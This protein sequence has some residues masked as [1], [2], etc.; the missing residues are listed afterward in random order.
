MKAVVWW[1]PTSWQWKSWHPDQWTGLE[2]WNHGNALSFDG[3]NDYV[4]GKFQCR[5][6][7]PTLAA[8]LKP[9]G[10]II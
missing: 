1:L 10:L 2:Q 3:E 5:G 8:G 7:Q 6:N 4:N 9:I